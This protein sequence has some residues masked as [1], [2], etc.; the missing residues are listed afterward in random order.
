MLILKAEDVRSALPMD[1]VIEAMKQAYAALSE[2]RAEVPLRSQLSIPAHEARCLFMPAYVQGSDDDSMVLK[3]VSLFPKNP[4]RNLPFIHAA[5]LVF[6]ADS[7][8]PE[9]LLE[10]GSLTAK[11]TG[12][13]S[14]AATDMLARPDSHVAAIFGAGVQGRT[15]LEAICTVRPIKQ[16]WIYDPNPENADSFL[17]D[18]S[19]SGPIPSDVRLAAN[20]KQAVAEADVICTATTS[21][22]PVFEDAHLKPGVHI[23]GVGSYTPTMAEIPLETILRAMVVVDSRSASLEEAG[24]LIQPIQSGLYSTDNIHAELGEI[25][26]GIAKGRTHANQITFFKSV[27]VAVQDALAA[28]LALKNAQELGIGQKVEW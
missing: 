1:Q 11:R 23:N 26:A 8:R 6:E 17:A 3:A 21:T 28:N 12:A 2:G 18:M 5:V 20:P 9:A 16:V 14:G 15:Q 19:G 7:G 22:I 27:G 4:G 13:A 24:D 25:V 10:G